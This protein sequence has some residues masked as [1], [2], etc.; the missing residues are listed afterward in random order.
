M[1]ADKRQQGDHRRSAPAYGIPSRGLR[2][3]VALVLCLGMTGV[4]GMNTARA[5]NVYAD[6]FVTLSARTLAMG[7]AST[8]LYDPS[9]VFINPAGLANAQAITL[10]YNHS[11]RHFPGSQ[12]GGRLEWDQLDGDTQALVVPLPLTTFAHGFT[13]DHEMGYDFRWHPEDG[14][15]GYPRQRF[16]GQEDIDAIAF[17][18][19][20]PI[21]AGIGVRRSTGRFKPPED[22]V[23]KQAWFRQGEGMHIGILAR[24][25]P[26]LDYGQS[27]LKLDYEWLLL[28]D[29]GAGAGALDV[30]YSDHI[31]ERRGWAL[32]PVGWLTLTSDQVT[33]DHSF[34]SGDKNAPVCLLGMGTVHEGDRVIER[35][36]SGAELSLGSLIK[37]RTGLYDGRRTWGAGFNLAGLWLNYTEIE[38][39]L[40][41]IVGDGDGYENLH[42]Y[43]F[44]LE[45]H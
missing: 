7:G 8:A 22:S 24:V 36:H 1:A 45:L 35:I 25:W 18:V 11:C 12:E 9:A 39:M 32:T 34:H 40:P 23:S 38:D 17:D 33:E 28:E 41:Q 44:Q 29:P 2:I 16:C 10:L 13:F 43:G 6:I 37:L 30:F 5:L 3:I 27:H 19:G 31:T 14:S 15:L 4:V 42:F 21:A 20:L 26:G